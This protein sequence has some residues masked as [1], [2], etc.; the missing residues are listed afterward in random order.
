MNLESQ[1]KLRWDFRQCLYHLAYEPVAAC[2]EVVTR[3]L[4]YVICI[5]STVAEKMHVDKL[6]YN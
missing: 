3:E 5:C 4:N 1:D 6:G 2:G